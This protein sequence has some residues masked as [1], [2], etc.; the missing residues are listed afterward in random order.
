MSRKEE[1]EKRKIRQDRTFRVLR[2]IMRPFIRFLLNYTYESVP[3]T[4]GEYILLCN[5]NTDLDP[6][7]LS[8][9]AG[10]ALSFVATEKITRMG[11]IGKLAVSLCDPI[12]HRKGR[13]GKNTV[14]A[15]LARLHEGR[16]VA[17]FPEGNRSFNGITCD[18]SKTNGR[19][20]K[21]S[22][23]T[24][25]TYRFEG[26]YFTS[27]RW[28]KGLRKGRIKGKLSGVYTP[29]Q[30]KGMSEDEVYEL[31]KKD[32][33]VD[34]Y[35]DQAADPVKY[36]GNRRAEGIETAVFMCPE[37]GRIGTLQSHDNEIECSCG[38]KAVYD[39]YGYLVKD[40]GTRLT[41][42]QM[43]EDQK[44]RLRTYIGS[45]EKGPLFTDSVTIGV[46][47]TLHKEKER[48]EAGIAAYRDRLAVDGTE[49]PYEMIEG[50]A[51]HRKN[52]LIVNIK[53]RE[54]HFELTGSKSFS[55]LKYMYLF[56]MI[57]G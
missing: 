42:T 13:S 28:G 27:P 21:S 40:D 5:H 39:E 17:M 23:S 22:G 51:V 20:I 54:D 10:R 43:D 56:R 29:E 36:L 57:K 24:L 18:I 55:A 9:A 34:A 11:L 8:I 53:D 38:F 4:D 44:K 25:V 3:E 31:L 16:S 45:N 50:L 49:Y 30:L 48:K 6:L 26:G 14:M 12:L 47:D 7:M 2:P 33:Y 46:I 15:I 32:L 35:A 19:L 52:L 37:C 1:L 41:V